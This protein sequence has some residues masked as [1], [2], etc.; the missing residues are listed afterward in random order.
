MNILTV[1]ISKCNADEFIFKNDAN[2]LSLYQLLLDTFPMFYPN[3]EFYEKK[4]SNFT[5]NPKKW[6]IGYPVW[7]H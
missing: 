3:D 5:P 6:K 7:K 4:C 2:K 1:Q